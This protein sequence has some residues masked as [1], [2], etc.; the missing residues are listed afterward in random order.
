[1][2]KLIS[3]IALIALPQ[4]ALAA[5]PE[6]SFLPKHG[7]GDLL[8]RRFDLSTVRSSLGPRR[9]PTTNTFASLG[10]RPSSAND[11]S[12]EF[13]T[14]DWYYGMKVLRRGDLNKDGIEDLEVCFTDR[15]APKFAT[16]NAQQALL[17]TRY[18]PDGN[19]VA[20]AY[21]MNGCETIP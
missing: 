3:L 2:K 10:L 1:M 16:Y 21:S 6:I 14:A 11:N 13:D 18:A 8:A 20:L 15:A 17:I 9:S 19:L 5:E 4:A 12:V 7:L